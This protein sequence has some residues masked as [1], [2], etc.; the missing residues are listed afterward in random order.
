MPKIDFCFSGWVRGASV[1]TAT[2]KDGNLL[3]VS[4]MPAKELVQKLKDGVLF[5][6]LGDYLYN[7]NSDVD[8]EMFDWSEST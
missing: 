7:N 3:D 4:G 6:S 1:T 5:I 8:I 2:D